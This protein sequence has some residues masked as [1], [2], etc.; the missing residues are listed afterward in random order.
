[1][2]KLLN[3]NNA[4]ILV[5][6]STWREQFIDA[7]KVNADDDDD[8]NGGD[9]KAKDGGEGQEDKESEEKQPSCFDYL[10]HFVSLFW[11]VLFAF[12]PPTGNVTGSI[13]LTTA[14]NS[15]FCFLI[16]LP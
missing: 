4:S 10:I 12:V 8:D 13:Y 5:G 1:V 6:T 3:K 16:S 14:L 7:I 2:D 9:D 11:K 15:A